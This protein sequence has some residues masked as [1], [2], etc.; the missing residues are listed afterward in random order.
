M[1]NIGQHYYDWRYKQA[2][3]APGPGGPTP[4]AAAA[5]RLPQVTIDDIHYRASIVDLNGTYC[6]I[7]NRDQQPVNFDGWWLDSPKWSY[8][9][10]FY[11]P[12]GITL[13]PGA[14]I[15]VHSGPGNNDAN[16]IYMF[17]TSV[18][19]D[20]QPYDLAVLYDNYGREVNRL[21]P[22]AETGVPPTPPPPGGTGTPPAAGTGTPTRPA[23]TVTPTRTVGSTTPTVAVPSA[24]PTGQV[25]STVTPTRG[26]AT[27]TATRGTV[28]PT[29]STTPGTAT[30]TVTV[31]PTRTPTP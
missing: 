16:D 11:F 18:M 10:R 7:T 15:N 14:S 20:G 31:T 19:W 26:T 24:Q 22:A 30:V 25:P 5:P 23:G 6:T 12:S 2:G 13:A 1:G 27:P 21:F 28:T 29:G 3:G 4:T 9:D 17:R 8:V